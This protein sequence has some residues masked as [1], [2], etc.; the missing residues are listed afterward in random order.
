M[1]ELGV[2]PADARMAHADR[3]QCGAR[4]AAV[5]EPEIP[6]DYNVVLANRARERD[7]YGEG[8][9]ASCSE[10]TS[11]SGSAAQTP[12]PPPR[13]GSLSSG[14]ASGHHGA[15]GGPHE[16]LHDAR[17][18][19][20]G[21]RSQQHARAKIVCHLFETEEVRSFIQFTIL[22]STQTDMKE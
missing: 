19:L 20:H 6:L 8:S 17:C 1:H 14:S 16:P 2:S 4:P 5:D 9:E 10:P 18:P 21:A 12:T 13:S 11:E 15:S 22:N 7:G 3:Y